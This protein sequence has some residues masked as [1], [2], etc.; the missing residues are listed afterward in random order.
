MATQLKTPFCF[1]WG[2]RQKQSKPRTEIKEI[3]EPV[4][5]EQYLVIADYQMESSTEIS[6]NAGS[7]VEVVEKTDKGDKATGLFCTWMRQWADWACAACRLSQWD[8]IKMKSSWVNDLF[9][10]F[11]IVWCF[12]PLHICWMKLTVI[13]SFI[14]MCVVKTV[15]HLA[16]LKCQMNGQLYSGICCFVPQAGGLSPQTKDRA[17]WP[18]HTWRG[19]MVKMSKGNSMYN[20]GTVRP[21]PVNYEPRASTTLL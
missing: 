20:P 12:V 13:D 19:W 3:S 8:Q 14:A 21:W 6:L 7:V 10:S 15:T 5:L 2:F 16:G 4:V 1:V 9:F 18:V 11:A 17:G